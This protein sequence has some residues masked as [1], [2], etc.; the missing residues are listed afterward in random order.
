LQPLDLNLLTREVL[1]LYESSRPAMQLE[2]AASLPLVSGDTAKLRQV[3]HNLLQNAEQ[4]VS[5]VAVPR[6]VVRTEA[7]DAGVQFTMRDNGPGFPAALIGRAFEPYVTTKA[8]GTGLGL[9]IVKKIVEEHNGRIVIAN[10]LSGGANVTI[11]LPAAPATVAELRINR[12]V[13]T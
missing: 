11:I 10:D 3:I 12:Q 8:K 4:A 13:G 5:D 1:G 6:I 2:L 9:A 7:I